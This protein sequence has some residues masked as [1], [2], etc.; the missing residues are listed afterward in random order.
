L[1]N[2]LRV[3]LTN[4]EGK[5][6]GKKYSSLQTAYTYKCTQIPNSNQE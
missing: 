4:K 6:K 2:E 5:G 3:E 1:L